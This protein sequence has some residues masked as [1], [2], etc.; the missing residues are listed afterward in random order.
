MCGVVVGGGG[1]ALTQLAVIEE[2]SAIE[3]AMSW[4]VQMGF[5]TPSQSV[6][7]SQQVRTSVQSPV[8]WRSPELSCFL[9]L[10]TAPIHDKSRLHR[11]Y[12]KCPQPDK[13][14]DH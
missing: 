11:V 12:W 8:R 9:S 13:E 7:D 6:E 14:S 3:T 1:G 4:K 10:E 5:E 2:G